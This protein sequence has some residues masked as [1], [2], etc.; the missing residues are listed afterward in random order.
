MESTKCWDLADFG[1]FISTERISIDTDA[2]WEDEAFVRAM[3]RY[4]ID[5]DLFGVVD[6]RRHLVEVDPQATFA[7]SL[8]TD[9]A[10]F[11]QL[12]WARQSIEQ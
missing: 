1:E 2:L 5:L 10:A 6:A 7:L 3:I 4:Y 9:A 8:F 12:P 11:R